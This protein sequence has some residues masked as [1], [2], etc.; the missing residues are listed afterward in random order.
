MAGS[1][2]CSVRVGPRAVVV[3]LVGGMMRA[4]PHPPVAYPSHRWLRRSC[5]IGRRHLRMFKSV[6]R[7]VSC[8]ESQYDHLITLSCTFGGHDNSGDMTRQADKMRVHVSHAQEVLQSWRAPP[9]RPAELLHAAAPLALLLLL[10]R[11]RL[12]RPTSGRWDSSA[13]AP[14]TT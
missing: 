14:A 2:S 1:C 4:L 13:A 10:H 5:C 3:L 9:A 12:R 6:Q 7:I 8:C 11:A